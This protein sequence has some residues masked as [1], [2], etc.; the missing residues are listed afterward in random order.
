MAFLRDLWNFDQK[1]N[2]S[3]FYGKLASLN[4]FYDVTKASPTVLK[5][6]QIKQ[7][8]A[9]Y[10][11]KGQSYIQ[12]NNFLK[13][14]L[15]STQSTEDDIFARLVNGINKGLD[16]WRGKEN[17]INK[18]W[19]K[20]RREGI[21]YKQLDDI[22]EELNSLVNQITNEN[23]IPAPSLDRIKYAVGHHNR[24]DFIQAKG[25]FLEEIGTWIMMRSGLAG[26]TT[27]AWK[28]ED[29]F[30]G[31]NFEASIIEDAMGLLL[32]N[33]S[34]NNISSN[35]FLTLKIEGYKHK[36][37]KNKQKADKNLQDWINSIKELNG[38]QVVNGE[39]KIGAGISS[40]QEFMDW[41]SLINNADPKLNLS[42]SL[43]T[44]LYEQIRK[45]S[46]NIQGKSNI[47]RHLA[48]DGRR[49]LFRIKNSA[50]YQQLVDFSKTASVKMHSAVSEEEFNQEYEEFVAYANYN[51]SKNINSTV[52]ARNE[53]Y[54]TK[55]GFSDLATLMEKRGFYIRLKDSMMSYNRFL[56]NNFETIYS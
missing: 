5:D 44:G 19:D 16:Q 13:E 15:G 34:F 46:V 39:V 45:L 7:L 36:S 17:K 48:N 28:A 31:E 21:Y 14:L 52:Y 37:P 11:A 41:M 54:I 27:G 50:E 35:N 40:T 22:I 4:N 20:E 30:F 6:I 3:L 26:F 1:K 56:K 38:A 12:L 29:K 47:E 32:N 49:S 51:L 9:M 43:S 8:K 55:E 18:N 24:N 2:P 23:G 33:Q 25:D 53:F 10:M 42:I